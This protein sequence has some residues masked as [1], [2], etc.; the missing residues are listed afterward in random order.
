MPR[1]TPSRASQRRH[2]VRDLPARREP[3]GNLGYVTVDRRK[4]VFA[5]VFDASAM[6][7][8]RR[9]LAITLLAD[10]CVVFRDAIG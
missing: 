8:F 7:A 4:A 1:A 3:P 9:G 6:K 2:V 10:S 5:R